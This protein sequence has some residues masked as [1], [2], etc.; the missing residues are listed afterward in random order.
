M[1]RV[2]VTQNHNIRLSYI[3]NDFLYCEQGRRFTFQINPVVFDV[4]LFHIESAQR[5][6]YCEEKLLPDIY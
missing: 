6:L 2:S 5:E 1:F 3:G 4:T